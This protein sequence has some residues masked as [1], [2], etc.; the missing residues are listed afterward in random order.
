[1][2]TTITLEDDVYEAARTLAEGSGQ[3]LGAVLSQLARRGLEPRGAGAAP[4]EGLPVFAVPSDAAVIPG[5]R[6]GELLAAEGAE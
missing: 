3:S 2:R 6:A 5:S 1:M 4:G